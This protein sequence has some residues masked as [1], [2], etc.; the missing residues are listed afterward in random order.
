MT[1]WNGHFMKW[2]KYPAITSNGWFHTLTVTYN[3][4]DRECNIYGL[5]PCLIST[6]NGCSWYLQIFCHCVVSGTVSE[7]WQS[8]GG[9]WHKPRWRCVCSGVIDWQSSQ[10][11]TTHEQTQQT[12]WWR[13]LSGWFTVSKCSHTCYLQRNTKTTR[14]AVRT[15]GAEIK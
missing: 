8:S 4:I 2:L 11:Q 7:A 12:R 5:F 3:W 15:C 1:E 10:L 6:A 13:V 9:F 14:K